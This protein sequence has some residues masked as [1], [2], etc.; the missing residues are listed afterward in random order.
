MQHM[1]A[2]IAHFTDFLHI[3]MST[4]KCLPRARMWNI[5]VRIACLANRI[6]C[7]NTQKVKQY[8]KNI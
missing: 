1:G 5:K 4:R 7:K 2:A 3:V 8:I 6:N